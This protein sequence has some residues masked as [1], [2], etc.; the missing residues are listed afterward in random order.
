MHAF[1]RR[2]LMHYEIYRR[3]PLGR[4]PAVARRS[5]LT[6]TIG[7][8]SWAHR[9]CTPIRVSRGG[10]S[11]QFGRAS[12]PMIP[13]FVHTIRGPDVRTGT[14]SDHGSALRIA[15]WWH[16]QH[17]TSS[18]RTPL[19]RMLASVIGSIGLL[20]RL[21]AIPPI[22]CRP[23]GIGECRRDGHPPCPFNQTSSPRFPQLAEDRPALHE[24][25]HWLDSALARSMAAAV[26]PLIISR[27]FRLRATRP[28]LAATGYLHI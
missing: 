1:L 17:D 2:F 9:D 22:V 20:M 26:T 5:A 6:R 8:A 16:C 11:C 15:R 4:F 3:Y 12:A 19:A 7:R 27:S 23:A 24:A 28:S 14:S 10:C 13:Q 25:D 21:T 18:D